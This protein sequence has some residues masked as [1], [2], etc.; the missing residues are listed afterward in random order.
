MGKWLKANGGPL[1]FVVVGLGLAG[2]TTPLAWI[3][4]GVGVLW[5]LGEQARVLDRIPWRLHRKGGISARFEYDGR[6]LAICIVNEAPRCEMPGSMS[7][8]LSDANG[9]CE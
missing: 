6:Y 3:I 1:A 2:F 7:W 8:F 5:F 4:V 9:S